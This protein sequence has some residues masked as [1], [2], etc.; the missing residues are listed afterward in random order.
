MYIYMYCV[1]KAI[2]CVSQ[3]TATQ[4]MEIRKHSKGQ[5][6]LVN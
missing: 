6:R 3:Q 2:K 1:T 5:K 4:L